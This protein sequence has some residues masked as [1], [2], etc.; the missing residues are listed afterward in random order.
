MPEEIRA[1][2]LTAMNTWKNQR[3]LNDRPKDSSPIAHVTFQDARN[4]ARGQSIARRPH[5]RNSRTHTKE[6]RIGPRKVMKGA[7]TV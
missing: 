5:L 1:K 7:G 3:W 6:H 2:I 4:A